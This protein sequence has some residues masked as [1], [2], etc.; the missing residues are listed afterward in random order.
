MPQSLCLLQ[1]D[2]RLCPTSVTLIVLGA[3]VTRPPFDHVNS[4]ALTLT[5]IEYLALQT[6]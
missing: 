4:P 2:E 6:R 5:A 3:G 1:L